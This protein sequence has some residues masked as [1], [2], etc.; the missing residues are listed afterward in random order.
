MVSFR[1]VAK[2]EGRYL[3]WPA[4]KT[5]QSEIRSTRH[6]VYFHVVQSVLLFIFRQLLLCYLQK[7]ETKPSILLKIDWVFICAAILVNFFLRSEVNFCFLSI[8]FTQ[9]SCKITIRLARILQDNHSS[10][11][12]LQDN[13]RLARSCKITIFCKILAR[14]CKITIWSRLGKFYRHLRI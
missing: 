4:S 14:S 1:L 2:D 5:L 8:F 11:K 6:K 9:E 7:F 3:Q 13:H 10:C 12:I